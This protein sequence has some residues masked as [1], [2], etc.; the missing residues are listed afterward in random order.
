MIPAAP[1]FT[2]VPGRLFPIELAYVP[3]NLTEQ[4]QSSDRLDPSPYLRLLERID[5]KYPA[6]ESGD[7]LVFL[8]GM[9]DIQ[10]RLTEQP[11]HHSFK[12]WG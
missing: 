9:A 5:A 6:T 3:L 10:V 11:F 8:P 1:V 7:L 12:K 2:Q 4:V